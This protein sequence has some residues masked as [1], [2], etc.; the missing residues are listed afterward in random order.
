MPTAAPSSRA[1][2]GPG[3][4]LVYQMTE[5]AVPKA[6]RYNTHDPPPRRA[7]LPHLVG[8]GRRGNV[9]RVQPV[10]R[11]TARAT[12]S[13]GCGSSAR[14]TD[15]GRTCRGG[16]RRSTPPT[17]GEL[18]RD[19]GG[20]LF[21]KFTPPTI[22]RQTRHPGRRSRARSWS[23]ACARTPRLGRSRARAFERLAALFQP[24][25]FTPPAPGRARRGRRQVPA[26]GRGERVS[27]RGSVRPAAGPGPHAGGWYRDFQGVIVGDVPVDGRRA[28]LPPRA[29]T[30]A[31][32]PRLASDLGTPFGSSGM[33]LVDNLQ[34]R[35][36]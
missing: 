29:I 12:P 4:R 32:A 19:D 16:W 5:R 9:G 2:A 13:S 20:Y 8:A 17:L 3:M 35:T 36:S 21:A 7:A 18:W 28:A 11:P 23:T 14:R 33:D 6:F 27:R 1:E 30:R 25:P 31:R 34:A 10:P 22:A 26:V 24:R 15:S